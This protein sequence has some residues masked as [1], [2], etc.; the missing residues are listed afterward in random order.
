MPGK[1][2][3]TCSASTREPTSTPWRP[4][5][6]RPWGP[7]CE[8]QT[9]REILPNLAAIITFQR[10]IMGVIS[11]VFLIIVVFGVANTMVMSVFERTREI[12]TMMAL[13]LRRGR[14]GALF[15]LEAA[16]LA[17]A[18][19]TAGAAVARGVVGA[20][21]PLGRLR[22]GGARQHVA[23]YHLVPVVP[24]TI[25]G[26]AMLASITGALLAAAYPAWK[27]TRLRP[28]EALRAV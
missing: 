4:G 12:G 13:G 7:D 28:V 1:V 25:V 17:S 20:A 18:G 5:C 6:A 15:V 21:G 9:W 10:V 19:A 2:T 14:I 16:F 26:L 8:V 27:A 22:G 3:A 24:P 11:T 23:R